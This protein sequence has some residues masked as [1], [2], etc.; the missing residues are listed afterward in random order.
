MGTKLSN[1]FFNYNKYISV[2]K[3][4]QTILSI[5]S[6]EFKKQNNHLKLNLENL[7]NSKFFSF[8]NKIFIKKCFDI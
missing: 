7:I 6:S 4:S 8:K 1:L 2:Y 5:R 3:T